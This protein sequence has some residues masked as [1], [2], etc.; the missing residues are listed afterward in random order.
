VLLLVPPTHRIDAVGVLISSGDDAWDSARIDREVEQ[1][2][3]NATA[4]VD[5]DQEVNADQLR[6][7]HP[8]MRYFHGL[9]RYQADAPDWDLQGK[10]VTAA[11]YLRPD[12]R[13]Y[14][15]VLRRLTWQ[16]Y[17]Q[18]MAAP[19]VRVAWG[20]FIRQGLTE[21]QDPTGAASWKAAGPGDRLPDERLQAIFDSGR[22]LFAELGI[23]VQ[24]LSGP[25]MAHEGKLYGSG[26]TV[27]S[28]PQSP[29]VQG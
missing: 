13:P 21:I 6:D 24:K 29:V 9:T 11:D 5:A 3:E 12:G 7:R 1:A 16:E 2:I 15:F 8:V 10:Q 27:A 22:G 26:G 17:E 20:A 25:L 14:R 19:S 28:P 18:C 23:A 4:K